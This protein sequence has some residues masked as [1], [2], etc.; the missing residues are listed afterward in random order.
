MGSS[1]PRYATPFSSCHPLPAIAPNGSDPS[2]EGDGGEADG[3]T[4]ASNNDGDGGRTPA[5]CDPSGTGEV[6]DASAGAAGDGG[7]DS[8]PSPGDIAAEEQ[9]W[10]EAMHQALNFAKAEGDP[11]ASAPISD[12]TSWK[13]LRT[14]TK[15]PP[16]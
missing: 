4:E 13:S 10:D 1:P 5:S 11:T 8:A 16:S 9:A 7:G 14:D 3:S 15:T 2:D 12:A 6:I